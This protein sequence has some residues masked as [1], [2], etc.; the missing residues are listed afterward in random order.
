MEVDVITNLID[1]S[2]NVPTQPDIEGI[3]MTKF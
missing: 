2:A 3:L 1:H